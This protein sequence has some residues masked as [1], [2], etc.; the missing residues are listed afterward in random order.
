M[1]TNEKEILPA[2]ISKHNWTCEKQIIILILP[3][4][5]E[6][7]LPYFTEK[8]LSASLHKKIFKS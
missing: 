2:Y 4:K 5:E 8:Q 6:E 3:N 1:Y 7:G